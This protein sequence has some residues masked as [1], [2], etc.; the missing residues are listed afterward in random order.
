MNRKKCI[1]CKILRNSSS[2][3]LCIAHNGRRYR[4]GV[5][6]KCTASAAREWRYKNKERTRAWERDLRIRLKTK[7]YNHYGNKCKGCGATE[8]LEIDHINNDGHIFRANV[9]SGSSKQ[10]YYWIIRNNFPNDLQLLCRS[11]NQKKR[12]Q[13]K[14]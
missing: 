6:R 7:V 5:C 4:S 3:Y 14:K 10:Y 13:H 1:R 2:F 12:Y 8:K 9:I 11:C